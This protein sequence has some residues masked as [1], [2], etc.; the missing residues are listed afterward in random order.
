MMLLSPLVLLAALTQAPAT[1]NPVRIVWLATRAVEGDSAAALARR[2]RTRVARDSSDRAAALGLATIARLTY[3]YQT[4]E[5]RYRRLLPAAG[6]A[7]DRY[8]AH[9]RLG[10]GEALRAN[11]RFPEADESFVQ[12][13]VD[14]EA[15]GDTVGWVEA[16][17]GLARVRARTRGPATTDSLFARAAGLVAGA[18]PVLRARYHCA[19][20]SVL[21]LLG[22][23]TTGQE[24]DAGAELARQAGDTRLR[25]SCRYWRA[26][27]LQRRGRLEEARDLLR[28]VADDQ[29]RTRDL[30]SLAST[31]SYR[32]AQSHSM[33]DYGEAMRDFEEAIAVGDVSGNRSAVANAAQ[34]LAFIW[35][36]LGDPD[37]GLR[38]AQQAK[39]LYEVQGDRFGLVVIDA[40]EAEGARNAGRLA[41]ALAAG[42]RA[43][44]RAREAGNP[45]QIIGQWAGLID[46]TMAQGD[47]DGAAAALDSVEAFARSR[48]DAASARGF[49]DRRGL[50]ALRRGNLDAAQAAFEIAVAGSDSPFR[51][52]RNRARLAEIYVR[53]GDLGRA[54]SELVA[55]V[56]ALDRWRA[57]LTDR[58]LR[59]YIFQLQELWV[60]Y[61]LGVATIL[62][63]LAKGRP[64]VA[65][66]LAERGRARDL[67]DRLARG[68]VVRALNGAAAAR[69]PAAFHPQAVSSIDEIR[70][71]LPDART[72]I[73]VYVTG[74]GGEPTT[75]FAVTRGEITAHRVPPIDSLTP[76]VARVVG[77]LESGT[78]ASALARSLG[79]VLLDSALAS[80]GPD[81]D[82]IVVVPDDVLHRLPF[83][84]L[85]L[86][87]G[88]AV[89]E[90]Y[91]VSVS[92]SA[93]VVA[94]LWRRPARTGPAALLAFGD[95]RFENTGAGEAGGTDEGAGVYRAAFGASGG[96]PRLRES[97]REVRAAA[98]H[99]SRAVVR[100]RADASEAFLKG[101]PLDGYRVIHFATHA[102]VD[103]GGVNRTA[104][105]LAPGGGEDGFVG[106]SDLAALRLDAD[107][108]VLSACRTAAGAV[109][110]GEGV[111]GLT[112]PL[113]AAGARAVLAT[114]WRVGDRATARFIEAF[115]VRLAGGMPAADALRA[116][117]LD[118]R[119]AGAPASEWAA[120]TL[121]GD[122][123]VRPLAR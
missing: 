88:R 53:R 87:D 9:A 32:G 67:L 79:S 104:L 61:D 15:L 95:P 10:Q 97:G 50:T 82:H 114:L 26:S 107:L 19:R 22:A 27:D 54:E 35:I 43:L 92:P 69:P 38:Y 56:D 46:L 106:P 70:A 65:F 60:D 2:W 89:L 101:A 47:W 36:R 72:G 12:A 99:A 78:E 123:L 121:V 73:L 59:R 45:T 39:R 117:Q 75:V 14:A 6:A 16:L 112:A 113:L 66:N 44:T 5:E 51:Q 122:P 108:V 115:Y 37:A 57:E 42:R 58:D 13:A 30:A 40:L 109:V 116:A 18:D 33:G 31:L 77:L 118:A 8:A 20:A 103:D 4:A 62:A 21:A 84:A 94:R 17:L 34:R 120:F 74:R 102:L 98:R 49:A 110:R 23:L 119:R 86:P 24:A 3:Q 63:E 96:L 41:D 68:D 93:S 48:G 81:V 105:A 83:G 80:L 55:A 25:A 11:G 52:Y 71:A 100:L 91:T 90:R 64:A 7:P 76:V 29:R 111:Q 1:N 85:S 28:D